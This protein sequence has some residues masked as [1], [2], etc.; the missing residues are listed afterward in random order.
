MSRYGSE[1]RTPGTL[2]SNLPCDHICNLNELAAVFLVIR[3]RFDAPKTLPSLKRKRLPN[4]LTQHSQQLLISP[5]KVYQQLLTRHDVIG[6]APHKQGQFAHEPRCPARPR[7]ICVIPELLVDNAGKDAQIYLRKFSKK[8]LL[9]PLPSKIR[10]EI[11]SLREV[12]VS[13][14]R[15][16]SNR[17]GWVLRVRQ[18]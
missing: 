13:R 8:K 7:Q 18:G 14:A 12:C 10:D 5:F 16:A 6:K 1:K 4:L 17:V 3:T 11:D 15:V 9:V 2:P